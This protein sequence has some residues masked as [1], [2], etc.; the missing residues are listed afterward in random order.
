MEKNRII[1][2]LKE[3]KNNN[4]IFIELEK[5]G[6][7]VFYVALEEE[8]YDVLVKLITPI[9]Y[10]ENGEKVVKILFDPFSTGTNDI[11]NSIERLDEPI[12]SEILKAIYNIDYDL[13]KKMKI[14]NTHARQIAGTAFHI[15]GKESIVMY[16]EPACLKAGLI[17]KEKN[18]RTYSNDTNGVIEDIGYDT[19]FCCIEIFYK[20]LTPENQKY[21]NELVE[22]GF[23]T[24]TSSGPN[25]GKICSL[26][27]PCQR[28]E[29][30]EV[31]SKRLETLVSGFRKQK[32]V[33]KGKTISEMEDSL[34]GYIR[35]RKSISSS[36]FPDGQITVEGILKFCDCVDMDIVYDEETMLFWEREEFI[37]MKN[38]QDQKEIEIQRVVDVA[39]REI[40]KKG[41]YNLQKGNVIIPLVWNSQMSTIPNRMF[42]FIN[43]KGF[44]SSFVFSAYLIHILNQYGISAQ[45]IASEKDNGLRVSVLYEID[46]KEYI[47]NPGED[48]EYFT[49][50]GISPDSRD[51]YYIG[52]T[53]VMNKDGVISNAA[54][55]TIE[56]YSEKFGDVWVIGSMSMDSQETLKDQIDCVKSRCIA[57]PE[58]AN[59]ALKR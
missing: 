30:V 17:L 3:F 51:S 5:Y 47:A 36:C 27:V 18:I 53:T 32:I 10:V 58:H 21:I 4:Q 45:M 37:Y 24:I 23:A 15:S 13:F 52:D 39:Y 46:G 59:Y 20:K 28:Y 34:S 8:M 56:E 26:I 42:D 12:K 25:A 7:S 41:H 1:K 54:S 33:Y 11:Y 31:V 44:G 19:G 49:K 55:Y 14:G 22:K 9:E 50:K 2:L 43:E 29:T 16:F 48:I 40:V 6:I 38:N 57:P 35:I